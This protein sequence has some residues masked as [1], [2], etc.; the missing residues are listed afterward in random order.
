MKNR[1]IKSIF[2]LFFFF[3]NF[4]SLFAQSEN[5]LKGIELSDSVYNLLK[6]TDLHPYTQSL[7]TS[8]EN[9]FPYNILVNIPSSQKTDTNLLLIFF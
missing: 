1:I 9:T 2:I 8:V 7:V 4:F 5:T 3:L 6:S